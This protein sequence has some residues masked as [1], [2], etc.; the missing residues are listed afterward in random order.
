[1]FVIYSST[2]DITQIHKKLPYIHITKSERIR[3]MLWQVADQTT[4]YDDLQVLT[5][6]LSTYVSLVLSIKI[7]MCES[8]FAMV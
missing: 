5:A 6:T 2:I 8:C 1:M 4:I 7:E 3:N